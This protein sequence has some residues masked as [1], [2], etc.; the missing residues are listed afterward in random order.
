MAERSR[1]R[2]CRDRKRTVARGTAVQRGYRFSSP[3]S[4]TI[5]R[6]CKQTRRQ[7]SSD[8]DAN[9]W[10]SLVSGRSQSRTR[11]G[12]STDR[13]RCLH[14]MERGRMYTTW[15]R[16]IVVAKIHRRRGTT[17]FDTIFEKFLAF[18]STPF[19]RE[20]RVRSSLDSWVHD[21]Q[22]L[23]E[24]SKAVQVR[25]IQQLANV[26]RVPSSPVEYVN[27]YTDE[28]KRVGYT[29]DSSRGDART[30]LDEKMQPRGE[31]VSHCRHRGTNDTTKRPI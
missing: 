17:F 6:Q 21:S 1:T 18:R 2:Y 25:N 10:L 12:T 29:L 28:S 8:A 9:A 4:A 24:F 5:P 30:I 15:Y 14:R 26:A 23:A 7:R 31:K 22:K 16:V 13:C 3:N 27:A 11:R 19:S 20:S